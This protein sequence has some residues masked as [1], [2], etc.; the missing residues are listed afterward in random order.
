MQYY[1]LSDLVIVI[2]L[3]TNISADTALLIPAVFL[4]AFLALLFSCVFYG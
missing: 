4:L 1:M 2:I 3:G